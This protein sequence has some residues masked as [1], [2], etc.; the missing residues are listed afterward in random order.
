MA[1]FRKFTEGI[2]FF[3]SPSTREQLDKISQERRIS[4]SE[5]L[6]EIIDKALT[7]GQKPESQ[8][9]SELIENTYP[10]NSKRS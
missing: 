7:D 6:R 5:L 9:L 3:V 2:S 8:S 4:V 10:T 1:T